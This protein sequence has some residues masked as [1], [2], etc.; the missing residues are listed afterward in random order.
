MN[1]MLWILQILLTLHTAVGA[2]W[3]LSNSAQTMTSLKAIPSGVWLIL[4]IMEILCSM[5]LILPL[6]KKRLGVLTP[7]AAIVIAAEMLLFC[8]VSVFSGSPEYSH[9]TYWLI[10][11]AIAGFIA[12]G[13]IRVKF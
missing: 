13:R 9:V 2:V 11:A 5:A 6:I 7:I 12:F 1:I 8:A 3:K 4:S 10:V